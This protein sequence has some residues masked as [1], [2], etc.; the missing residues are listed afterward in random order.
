MIVLILKKIQKENITFNENTSCCGVILLFNEYHE[1]LSGNYF[2]CKKRFNS[3]S[4]RFEGN[5]ELLQEYNDIIKRKLKLNV[6]EKYHH[7]KLITLIL[8][9]TFITYQTGWDQ[10]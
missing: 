8:S 6:V 2:N 9:E 1:T 5:N 10:G 7:Q 3:L 4:E